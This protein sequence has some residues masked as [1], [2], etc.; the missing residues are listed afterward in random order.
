[1]RFQHAGVEGV[2]IGGSGCVVAD[3]VEDGDE[4][5]VGLAVHLAELDGYDGHLLPH[6]G[7][8]EIRAGVEGLQQLA[9]VVL[10]HRLA[11][12]GL[13]VAG[14]DAQQL[15]DEV[16]DV[17]AHHRYLVDDDEFDLTDEL[18]LGTRVLQ[19]LLDV[20][21]VVAR[22]VGQQGVEWQSEEAVERGASGVDGRDASRG[23]DHV[24][25]LGG[26][27]DIFQERRLTRAGLPCE[28]ER[29]TGIV[30]DLEGILPLLVIEVEFHQSSFMASAFSSGAGS[31]SALSGSGS[32]LGRGSGLP[33]SSKNM[34]SG[35]ALS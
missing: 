3:A 4:L 13:W 33:K 17:C 29:A 12:E 19:R 34:A 6:L 28:K 11:A 26:L 32:F 23:E 16:D 21:A 25:L 18:A 14:V 5:I 30:D 27:C 7:V 35:S 10:E 22:I 15:V 31:L 20:A 24:L 1:M 8:E 9:V 2:E